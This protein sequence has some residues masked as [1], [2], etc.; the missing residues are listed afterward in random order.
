MGGLHSPVPWC[1][2]DCHFAYNAGMVLIVATL[3]DSTASAEIDRD[4]QLVFSLLD[5]MSSKG[6]E[7]AASCKS[8]LEALSKARAPTESID[9]TV[10]QAINFDAFASIDPGAEMS[11][12]NELFAMEVTSN[13]ERGSEWETFLQ[14][15]G[16]T[17]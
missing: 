6:N 1:F 3:L 4:I 10:F 5:F 8:I 17:L 13:D 14:S 7:S 2:F 9:A 12:F 15:I 16:M 11:E